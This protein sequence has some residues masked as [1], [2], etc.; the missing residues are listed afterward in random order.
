MIC[1][2]FI[3]SG[4]RNHTVWHQFIALAE[5]WMKYS[6]GRRPRF[7]E[8]PALIG[9]RPA[10]AGCSRLHG[11]CVSSSAHGSGRDTTA[12]RRLHH[13]R[14]KFDRCFTCRSM[15][16]SQQHLRR[17]VTATCARSIAAEHC[18]ALHR[19]ALPSAA[20]EPNG[21]RGSSFLRV[22]DTVIASRHRQQSHSRT[23]EDCG[24]FGASHRLVRCHRPPHHCHY[25]PAR[26]CAR[27]RHRQLRR[28]AAGRC[29]P[30][31]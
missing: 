25:R 23:G 2:N 1:T 19:P 6:H 8:G 16:S 11:G 26:H 18:S 12:F 7:A 17:R 14:N 15:Q 13:A 4:Q 10:T 30:R 31:R 3:R 20:M 9:D 28:A 27:T 24:S 5:G 29:Y 22:Y 21:T